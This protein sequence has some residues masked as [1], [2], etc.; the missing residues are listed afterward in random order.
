MMCN[1]PSGP[2][3]DVTRPLPA[4]HTLG[5]DGKTPGTHTV[6]VAWKMYG[7]SGFSKK[8]SAVRP[9]EK[10]AWLKSRALSGLSSVR[11]RLCERVA[12]SIVERMAR[13]TEGSV[14]RSSV[15]L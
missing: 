2:V 6:D 14:R 11:E 10:R 12:E 13:L 5:V 3:R 15:K 7:P 4:A 1:S 8:S 9:K